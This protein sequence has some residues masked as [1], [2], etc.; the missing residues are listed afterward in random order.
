MQSQRR[1]TPYSDLLRLFSSN[2]CRTLMCTFSARLLTAP[3][4]DEQITILQTFIVQSI[5]PTHQYAQYMVEQTYPVVFQGAVPIN[6][7]PSFGLTVFARGRYKL[8]QPLCITTC[9]NLNMEHEN[10]VEHFCSV[11]GSPGQEEKNCLDDMNDMGSVVSFPR[12]EV[13]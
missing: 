5:R 13:N 1:A 9:K 12:S 10:A 8:I 4:G 3:K 6:H 7:W 11:A 2:D